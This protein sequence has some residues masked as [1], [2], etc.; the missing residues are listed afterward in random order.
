[1]P[2]TLIRGLQVLDGSVQRADHDTT[3]VG[4]ATVTKLVQGS[5]ITLSS[6]GADAGTGDV[7]VAVSYPAWTSYT[8]TVTPGAGTITT[9]NNTSAYLQI[10]KLI[11][12][13]VNIVIAAIGTASGTMA[14]NLPVAA[15]APCSFAFR[16]GGA[17]L[18]HMFSV[19]G[20]GAINGIV[21]KY[22]NTNPVWAN[23]FAISVTG[24]YEA[25]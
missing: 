24:S 13:R 14:L 9:Q 3:T 19:T 20:T 10:G 5:N 4:Q 16:D 23:N 15:K 25:A 11:F 22:D 12:V 1:M 6:T 7:T 8:A 17:G 18:T 21:V 2:P